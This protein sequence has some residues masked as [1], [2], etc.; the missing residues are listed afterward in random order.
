MFFKVAF[1]PQV[2]QRT[3]SDTNPEETSKAINRAKLPIEILA[4]KS[5]S[6][7]GLR[8]VVQS[9][10]LASTANCVSCPVDRVSFFAITNLHTILR[11]VVQTDLR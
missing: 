8:Q 10:G 4:K 11:M 6:P 9:G 2:L 3:K 7:E 5:E 1:T